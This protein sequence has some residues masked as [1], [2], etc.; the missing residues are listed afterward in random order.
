MLFPAT[1]LYMHALSSWLMIHF[2][3]LLIIQMTSYK[4]FSAQ[5]FLNHHHHRLY[6]FSLLL[7]FVHGFKTR[8]NSPSFF[9]SFFFLSRNG[10]LI[11][12][13]FLWQKVSPKCLCM[14]VC[15]RERERRRFLLK[16]L[17][18]I[19]VCTWVGRWLSERVREREKEGGKKF[20]NFPDLEPSKFY[21]PG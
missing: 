3:A 8:H 17:T 18:F 19:Y 16:W 15:V 2:L 9:L 4:S 20:F 13:H 5:S 1:T 7:Y 10:L 14:C 6:L 12:T 21:Y 11:P